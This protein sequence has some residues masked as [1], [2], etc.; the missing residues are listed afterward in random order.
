[1]WVGTSGYNYAEWRGSFYPADLPAAR[2]LA[3][4]AERLDTVELNATFYRM[5]T[6]TALET[7]AR[8]APDDFVFALKAH[9]RI[10]HLAR[11]RDVDEPVRVFCERAR[12]LG[13]KLGPV[14]FQLPPSFER[15]LARLADLLALLPADLAFAVEFRHASWY[16]D[17]VYERLRGRNVA[18]CVADTEAGTTPLVAT[19]DFGYLRLRDEGYAEADLARW[20]AAIGAHAGGWRAAYVYFKHEASGAGPAFAARLRRLFQPEEGP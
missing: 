6:V 3:Y 18:L 20:A 19:A 8:T 2:M 1:M 14:L 11:L 13:P 5:P 4:Y 15:D 12:A 16:A 9:R 7:W 10:T 17:E